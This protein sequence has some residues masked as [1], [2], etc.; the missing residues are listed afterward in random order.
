M[1]SLAF[2]AHCSLVIELKML[3]LRC[4]GLEC[5][6]L[7]CSHEGKQYLVL[8][9]GRISLDGTSS[10]EIVSR[11]ASRGMGA[12]ISASLGWNA[13]PRNTSV[14]DSASYGR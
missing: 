2:F 4:I 9:T 6:G 7:G 10:L 11:L 13:R 8:E 5:L 3:A 1:R 14:G 12:V